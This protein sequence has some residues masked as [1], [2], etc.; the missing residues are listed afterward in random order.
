MVIKGNP[1]FRFRK[2]KFGKQR[3][4]FVNGKV[5]E[6]KN[7]FLTSRNDG[8]RHFYNPDNKFTNVKNGHKHKL[9]FVRG[10]A[11]IAGKNPHMHKLLMI[12]KKVRG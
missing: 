12:K 4:A 6:V 3:L 1:K 10:L 2:I 8:H 7:F 5:K 9:N 11:L